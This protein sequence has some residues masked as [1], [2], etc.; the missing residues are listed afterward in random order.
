M[1]AV[2]R[3]AKRNPSRPPV[4]VPTFDKGTHDDQPMREGF[5]LAKSTRRIEAAEAATQLE[6]LEAAVVL[7][8]RKIYEERDG[9]AADA[10]AAGD[11]ESRLKKAP[12]TMAAAH[13]LF[14]LQYH[15]SSA[16]PHTAVR[17]AGLKQ[18]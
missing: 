6:H 10:K 2:V 4:D 15:L 7:V 11:Y 13:S 17:S 1:R 9:V 14:A 3:C 18:V 16:K 8:A 5:R 12:A